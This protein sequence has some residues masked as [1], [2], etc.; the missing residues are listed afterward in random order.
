M[1]RTTWLVGVLALVV[2]SFVCAPIRSATV[3]HDV[4]VRPLDEGLWLVESESDWNGATIG[5]NALIL[6]TSEM[7]L[8]VDTPWTNEQTGYLL[9]WIDR[10]IGL[11]VRYLVVTHGH[12]DRIGGIAE[13][14]KRGI[15]TLGFQGTTESA[16]NHGYQPPQTTFSDTLELDLGDD[17]A[18]LLYPG[19][20]HSADNIVVW[21]EKRRLLYGGCLVKNLTS[22]GLG[23]T[24]DADLEAW[25]TSLAN[26][27]GL[28]PDPTMVIPGHGE[29][30]DAALIEHTVHLLDQ[31]EKNLSR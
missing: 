4:R 10:E 31:H 13:A 30:G 29:V 3:A 12:Q 8:M 9:D 6:A 7:V 20:G 24:G 22:Q 25:P 15:Q 28:A 16:A 14:H 5:A 26:V 23:Y 21:F 18:R 1:R 27:Q 11:P 17:V 2:G 19:P